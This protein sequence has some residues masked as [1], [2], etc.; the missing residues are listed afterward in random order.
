MTLINMQGGALSAAVM[1]AVR[2][3]KFSIRELVA[4][5]CGS[6]QGMTLSAFGHKPRHTDLEIAIKNMT[7]R[8]VDPYVS[9]PATALH[10]Q[11]SKGAVFGVASG[12]RSWRPPV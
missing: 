1:P 7:M 11:P 4:S 3:E 6:A 10:Q 12:W 5:V 8:D 9:V 2:H